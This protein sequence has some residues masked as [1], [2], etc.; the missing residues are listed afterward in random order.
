[1]KRLLI[2]ML[3][4]NSV[5]NLFS[6]TSQ[7][8]LRYSQIFNNGTAR[9]Q[10]L[11]GAMGAVGGDFSC[12]TTNPAGLG[13]YS[14]SEFTFSPALQIEHSNSSF[15]SETNT[16]NKVNVGMG[17]LGLV[18]HLGGS[19]NSNSGFKGFN[20]AFGMNRES[21]FNNK[22]YMEGV[23]NK[24]SLLTGYVNTLNNTSGGITPQMINDNY[25]FDI[26]LAYNTN[27]IYLIDSVNKKYAND[28]PNGGVIQSKS[29][30]TGGSINEFDFAFG[31]NYN[32]R[33][34]IG[35]TIGIPVINYWEN[36][37]YREV[38]NDTAIHY[39]RSMTFNQQLET[40]GT[41]I[42]LKVGIIYRPANWVRIG[43][44]IHTPTYYGN[45]R[46]NWSS[47]MTGEF[48]FG[49]NTAYSPLGA[50]DYQLVTPFRA[51][52]SVAFIIGNYGLISGEYEYVNYSQSYFSASGASYSDVNTE[53]KNQYKAPLN[54]RF[55]TEW[56]IQNFRVRGG[57]GYYGSPYQSGPSTADMYVAS[58]G[59]G[60]RIKHFFFDMTY[61]WS[62]TKE[63]YYFY[64]P[65]VIDPSLN[66]YT[67]SRVTTTF[68]FRF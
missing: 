53:I 64:D 40:H 37:Q 63:D 24:N 33:L 5:T 31:T 61:Q 17:N 13:L 14:S 19:D 3:L 28:A 47:D 7:D 23:N 26:A 65:T 36:T 42:N 58:I 9:S 45:M 12:T 15:N 20:I 43:A 6:R 50:F 16:D 4:I 8:A 51:I 56:R 32:D 67:T 10:G 68:G 30:T 22:V 38:R 35:A 39:F 55:G 11:G 49:T 44:A 62:Q 2:I 21:D 66:T 54:V 59:W 60:Y 52:G 25:P 27:L 41:G 29:V 48:T 1:M 57:F 18:F 34:Y 46:D